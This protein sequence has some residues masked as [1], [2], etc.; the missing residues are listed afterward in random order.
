MKRIFLLILSAVAL[1]GNIYAAQSDYE[2]HIF[3]HVCDAKTGEMLPYINVIVD[4]TTIGTT[5]DSTGHYILNDVPEN[6]EITIEVSAL[7]YT[8]V[9]KTVKVNTGEPIEIDFAIIE[10]QVSLDAVVV[11]AN[12]NV[13]TRREAPSLV[14]VLDTRLFEVTTSPTVAEGLSFQSGVR[15]ENNCQNCGFN[16]VR[17]NG[18]D[19]HYSQILIDSRPV[20]SA[21][22]GV[23]GL[24]H[25][26]S[27]MIERIEVV[28]GGGSALYG[29]SAIGGTV[30]IITK[31][32]LY[33]SAN[34]AHTLMSI[35]C[36]GSLDNNTTFN[37]SLV[38]D[39]RKAGVMI[40]GQNRSRNG[41]DHDGDGYV[42][43]G[44][45]D[46]QTIGTRAYIKT[47]AYS[48]LSLEYHA[49][50]EY[51]RGGDQLHLPPHQVMVAETTD[52]I[53][54][55]GGITF[56]G[57][58]ADT[59]HRYSVY[60]S[61]QD[62]KRDSYY[63]S[64]MDPNAYGYTHGF[65]A[66]A[67][68]QY[69]YR[70]AKFLFLPAELTVGAEYNLD[71]MNDT[72]LG[73]GYTPTNQTIH[74]YSAY[75]QNEWKNDKW[76]FLIGGRMDKHNLIDHVIFS[77]RVNFR[78][79]PTHNINIRA[80]YS[81]GF[82]APQAFDEDLHIT[83]VGGER[84]RI[85]LAD[86]LK[87]ER[88]HTFSVS[89]DMYHTFNNGVQ[90]NLMVEGF[91]TILK[92]VFTLEETGETADDGTATVLER[93]NG[94]GATVMGVN[95][96]ARVAFNPWLQFQIGGTLQR[97]RYK[98]PEKWS[99][100]ESVPAESRM[101]RSPDSY[102]YMTA[103]VTPVR[104]F[105][106]SLTGTYTGPMLVQHF[107]GYIEKD[108]ARLTNAFFDMGLKLSYDFRIYRTIGLQ[109]NGGIKNI[110]NSYQRDFDKYENRDAGYIYG[111][112]LPRTIFVGAKLSF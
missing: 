17:L 58:T 14:S 11:S 84:T 1:V 109:I 18:L 107:A 23:Y 65:T 108:E 101:F 83:I 77:P 60:A 47:S 61:A 63:G 29:A 103:T 32:P 9:R 104:R 40:Y 31:E 92:D 45:I 85:R 67:G 53:I 96:E 71:M 75:L 69:M 105:D 106:I 100:E 98:E 48:K 8:T 56:E 6:E 68:A 59:R 97:S 15:V 94:S 25:L 33:N 30:N 35:G 93:R 54:N 24:E 51:R 87:E 27:N 46:G 66:V 110:F 112:S 28:R 5:T 4:G 42:E 52:H 62:V 7:G 44:E 16:Q 49:T 55:S 78:Y 76:G 34:V 95:L 73:E 38:T 82:R 13:T 81:S 72:P 86:D 12:R 2:T 43:I 64:N 39:N 90:G 41:Y 3:G 19:G 21:L 20:F 57:T 10:E 88:S 26:P 74:I 50:K 102:G 37:A 99:E 22:A 89:A 70:M 36:T 111:P 91:Y 80:V 79:N